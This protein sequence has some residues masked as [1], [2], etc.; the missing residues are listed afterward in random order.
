MGLH[1]LRCSAVKNLFRLIVALLASVALAA[2]V[3]FGVWH[4]AS[5]PQ[6]NFVFDTFTDSDG[7]NLESHV[8][9]TGATWT[10]IFGGQSCKI[11]SNEVYCPISTYSIN[12]ASGTSPATNFSVECVMNVA[13]DLGEVWIHGRFSTS[14]G[15]CYRADITPGHIRLM[16]NV[17][18]VVLK[19]V[20]QTWTPGNDYTITLVIT[21]AL[22][23]IYINGVF[24]TSDTDNTLTGGSGQLTGISAVS[25]AGSTTTGYHIKSFRAY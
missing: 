8:G 13:S 14:T 21:D 12:Y 4:N 6:V 18:D 15:A 9:E 2:P 5:A 22:K 17:G 19:D 11:N 3:N 10:N 23:S 7:T 16:R 1:F 20:V 24:V 25:P